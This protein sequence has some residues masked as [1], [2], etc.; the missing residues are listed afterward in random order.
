MTEVFLKILNMSI[1]ASWLVLAVIGLRFCL[2]KAPKWIVCLL[3]GIV[4][5]RLVMPF[6]LESIFSLIPSPE[7]FPQDIA[8]SQTPV[9]YSG[10]PAVNSAVNP[11]FT[12]YADNPLE[13]ILPAAAML[14]LAGMTVMLLCSLITYAKLRW[15]LQTAFRQDQNIYACDNVDSPFILGILRPRIYIPSGMEWE[16]LQY[17]L[18]HENAHIRRRDHLW[19]PLGFTLLTVYW[20]NP[21]LWLAYSLLC[22]DIERACDEKVVAGMDISGKK[23]YSKALLDCSVHRRTVM[24]CPVAFGE[25]DVKTRIKGV[26][27]YRKP[28]FWLVLASAAVCVMVAVCFL[29]DPVPCVH[30]YDERTTVHA[31]CTENGVQTLTCSLCAHS[32]TA[33]TDPT[34]HAYDDGT[35]TTKPNC[36]QCG[37]QRFVCTDCGKMKTESIAQTA[38]IPGGMTLVTEPNCVQTGKREANCVVCHAVCREETLPANDVHDLH[39]TVLQAPT[40]EAPGEGKIT[41][42]RCDHTQ[43]CAYEALGHS[44]VQG[45]VIEARCTRKGKIQWLCTNCGDEQWTETPKS[46]KHRWSGDVYGDMLR[47]EYCVRCRTPKP[48]SWGGG[49][50]MDGPASVSPTFPK[51]PTL[52]VI[53]WDL[54][55][56]L[57]P[58]P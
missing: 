31:T 32:Y 23:G 1:A 18:A 35:V 45:E 50:Y 21:L 36:T 55:P 25:V 16:Q 14:W 43:M 41:C 42:S 12:E 52:P 40:C 33:L 4:A 13:K 34:A 3:W 46:T 9:I 24:A 6:S 30:S 51:Q 15:Q 22:R 53:V 56:T 47:P 49:S 29:T 48:G 2:K 7:V 54:V 11:I 37:S 38:H 57:V 27:S 8:Q 28:A 5:L 26:L 58:K 17:V 10:I 20:F 39:E 19:K 44:Y